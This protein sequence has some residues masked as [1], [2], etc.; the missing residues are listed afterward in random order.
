MK[1]NLRTLNVTVF[2]L[3]TILPSF[4]QQ[5]EEF[6]KNCATLSRPGTYP[7]YDPLPHYKIERREYDASKP[8]A[9]NLRI[10]M[11]AR[12]LEG[13]AIIRVGCKL[14]SD[15]Q[16]ENKIHALFFDD[17]ASAR[18][19]A[20]MFTDQHDHGILLWHLRAR[21]ELNKEQHEA[22]VEYLLPKYS[23]GLLDLRRI[24]YALLS[25]QLASERQ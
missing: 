19:L 4:A 9:L 23:G 2:A 18:K 12:S 14:I 16:H 21:F 3:A 20:P 8:P 24:R 10:S 5:A 6:S 13:A 1:M 22:F 15:F 17:E 11:P 7:D 25:D